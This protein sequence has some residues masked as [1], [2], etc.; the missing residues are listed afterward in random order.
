M[1]PEGKGWWE[2]YYWEGYFGGGDGE[3]GGLRDA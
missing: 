2:S 3:V 1:V